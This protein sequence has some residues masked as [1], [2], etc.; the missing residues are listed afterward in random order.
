MMVRLDCFAG[1]RHGACRLRRAS[2]RRRA[3]RRPLRPRRRA[4]RAPAPKPEL[5]TF[6]F[7][8]A[9]M[10]TH[11]RCRATISTNMPTAPGPRTR[12][13]RPTSPTTA[14]SPARRPVEGADPRRSSRKRPRIRHS[15]IGIAYASFLD[16]GGDRG[17]GPGSVRALARARSRA[18]KSQGRLCRRCSPRPTRIGIGTPFGRASSA[19]TT[20]SRDRY[21]TAMVQARPR[22]ARP[23]LLSV[24]RA[25]ARRASAPNISS[26]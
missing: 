24:G 20:S 18:L 23:R 26:I 7:D 1:C 11:G 15:K 25:E 5:G 10:D 19:R 22:H 3:P 2:H 6:G 8:I 21:V 13:S 16:D 14:C 12:R 9:G 17:Q 4:G